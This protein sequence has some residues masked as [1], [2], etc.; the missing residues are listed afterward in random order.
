MMPELNEILRYWAADREA[1]PVL[2]ITDL[3]HDFDKGWGGT[4]ETPGDPPTFVITYNVVKKQVI[5]IDASE[6]GNFIME[7][8]QVSARGPFKT[9]PEGQHGS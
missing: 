8:A 9:I 5:P 2:N 4:E 6:L 3:T 1:V 7:L